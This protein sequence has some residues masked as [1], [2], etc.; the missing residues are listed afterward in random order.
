MQESITI[1]ISV[2]CPLRKCTLLYKPN[3]P[4]PQETKNIL[5]ITQMN[6]CVYHQ[7]YRIFK[8]T[9]FYYSDNCG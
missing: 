2:E 8:Y 4:Q 1:V 5:Q 7:R 6:N 3:W 9:K